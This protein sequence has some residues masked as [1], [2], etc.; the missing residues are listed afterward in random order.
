M[1]SLKYAVVLAI[2]LAGCNSFNQYDPPR[3]GV[4]DHQGVTQTHPKKNRHG[5][6]SFLF[7]DD[8]AS[9][10]AVPPPDPVE[11]IGPVDARD[12]QGHLLC[13]FKRFSVIP[14]PPPVPLDQLKQLGPKDKDAIIQ[15]LTDHIDALRQYNIRV[16]DQ[17]EKQR[18]E[19][20]AE[21]KKWMA[22]HGE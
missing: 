19:Y 15:L 3:N 4:G 16:R 13:P 9:E 22:Q 20:N 6:L 8:P 10:P 7:P 17:Q 11:V 21:C 2:G 12:E 1:R 14:T 18:R 5:I